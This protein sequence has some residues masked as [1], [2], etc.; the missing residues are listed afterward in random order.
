VKGRDNKLQVLPGFSR[1]EKQFLELAVKLLTRYI[2]SEDVEL[3]R[4][5]D[6]IVPAGTRRTEHCFIEERN[7]CILSIKNLLR[8]VP[9]N[10][11]FFLLE[12]KVVID[13]FF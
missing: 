2:V 10:S 6:P 5:C 3:K 1:T 13:Q 8:P 4:S 11:Q 9:D 12:F 7:Q